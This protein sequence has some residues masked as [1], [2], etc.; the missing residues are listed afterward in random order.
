MYKQAEE[1]HP[2]T[3]EK[4]LY[5]REKVQLEFEQGIGNAVIV[6]AIGVALGIFTAVILLLL[7]FLVSS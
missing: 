3:E 5:P 4:Q 7:L 2:A 6:S 1:K